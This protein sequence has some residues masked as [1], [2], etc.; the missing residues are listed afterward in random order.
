MAFALGMA[1]WL[2]RLRGEADVAAGL[3][4]RLRDLATAEGFPFWRA[5]ATFELGWVAAARGHLDEGRTLMRDGLEGYRATG[6][7]EEHTSELQSPVH[8][9]C[10]LL[11]EKKKH[12]YE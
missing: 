1:A 6:R 10:R 4:R 7:S 5:Q 12:K 11:L 2:H 9:V 8:L 3:A